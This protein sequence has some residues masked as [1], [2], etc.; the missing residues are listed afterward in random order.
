MGINLGKEACLSFFLCS[1]WVPLVLYDFCWLVAGV[2]WALCQVAFKK[3]TFWLNWR[4]LVCVA[5]IDNSTGFFLGK[6]R[7]LFSPPELAIMSKFTLNIHCLF[8][9]PICWL[10]VKSPQELL[11][12][13]INPGSPWVC[14]WKGKGI[15]QICQ[16]AD[17][18]WEPAVLELLYNH[19]CRCGVQRTAISHVT[20]CMW[21]CAHEGMKLD[22][23]LWAQNFCLPWK[24]IVS[25][26]SC[27]YWLRFSGHAWKTVM[28]YRSDCSLIWGCFFLLGL[29][30]SVLALLLFCY[31]VVCSRHMLNKLVGSFFSRAI[32]GGPLG[33]KAGFSWN[34]SYIM[35]GKEVVTLTGRNS[36]WRRGQASQNQT[37][38]VWQLLRAVHLAPR[39]SHRSPG[40]VPCVTDRLWDSF[41]NH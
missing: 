39:Y 11:L 32:K 13:V 9:M 12:H 16:H 33:K 20:V 5:G 25:V 7:W 18:S 35:V 23:F 8:Q 31:C 14:D 26:Y 1:C 28:T 19:R 6:G 41:C 2:M 24:Q 3:K 34:R 15:V 27:E 30:E 29:Q 36:W 40:V 17:T 22:G 10:M 37:M 4:T 38:L 21:F